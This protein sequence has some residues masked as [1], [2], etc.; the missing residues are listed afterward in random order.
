VRAIGA[1]ADRRRGVDDGAGDRHQP[2]APEHRKLA[3]EGVAPLRDRRG[4]PDHRRSAGAPQTPFW[5][6]VVRIFALAR[7]CA[8]CDRAT[9]GARGRERAAPRADRQLSGGDRAPA[10]RAAGPRSRS[11][12]SLLSPD[13]CCWWIALGLLGDALWR[14]T[15]DLEGEVRAGAQMIV[16]ALAAQSFAGQHSVAHTPAGGSGP[17]NARRQRGAAPGGIPRSAAR[18]RRADLHRD[19]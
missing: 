4:R 14:S 17:T 10:R 6:G 7:S 9:G 11:R 13:R 19:R 12:S 2:R 15:S 8:R 16:Q 5:V 1:A 3:C 18:A